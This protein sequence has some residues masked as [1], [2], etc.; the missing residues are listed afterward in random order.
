[1]FFNLTLNDIRK[2]CFV[3]DSD[4]FIVPKNVRLISPDQFTSIPEISV[5]QI[6]PGR[7]ATFFKRF[8]F[9][10]Y[11]FWSLRLFLAADPNTVIITSGAGGFFLPLGFLNRLPFFRRRTILLWDLFVEYRLGRE[12]RLWFFPF[13]KFKTKWKEAI[14]RY[15]MQGY[16]LIIV[17]SR[18]EVTGLS[19][20]YR[21][22][23]SLFV[24]SPFKANHSKHPNYDLPLDNFVFSG[25]NGKRDYK[26]LVEAVRGTNIPVIISTTKPQFRQEI[27]FAPNVMMLGAPEP[28]FA[29]LQ[30]A[31]RFAVVSMID[32]KSPG[33]KGGGETNYCNAAWHRKPVIFVDNI[34]AQDYVVEGETG[35]IVPC[36]NV[37]LLRKRILQLWNDP[38]LCKRMG[39]NARKHVEKYFTHALFIRRL[40][41]LALVLGQRP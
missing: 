12:K 26:T 1:M 17:W 40:L 22:P 21:L 15:V 38:E 33:I 13:V 36:G 9:L 16:T 19:K 41:R 31:C 35:F 5:E 32:S 11:F 7:L 6:S 27:E 14:G 20:Y 8:S 29:Q 39:E 34:V 37:E 2:D 30:A 23:E 25:G 18:N 4:E 3:L 24:F 28:A 10:Y